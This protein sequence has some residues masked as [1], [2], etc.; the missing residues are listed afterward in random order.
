[1]ADNDDFGRLLAAGLLGFG[2]GL[3]ALVAPFANQSERKLL[4]DAGP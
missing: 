3:L 2:A 1:M 4:G